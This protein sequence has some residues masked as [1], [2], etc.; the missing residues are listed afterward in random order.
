M[1]RNAVATFTRSSNLQGAEFAGADLRGA[2][3][4]GADLSGVVM[5][6]AFRARRPARRRSGRP[7][8]GLG[9]SRT[10]LGSHRGSW[11][12]IR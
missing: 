6:F 8:R 2:R 1:K 11:E 4:V 3:F 5:R 7:L 9:R 12:S 10:H